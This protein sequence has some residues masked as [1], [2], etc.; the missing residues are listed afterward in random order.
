MWLLQQKKQSYNSLENLFD[1]PY[2]TENKY[3]DTHSVELKETADEFNLSVVLPGV[4]KKD[5]KLEYRDGYVMVEA[6]KKSKLESVTEGNSN[7]SDLTT[8]DYQRQFYVGDIDSKKI[9][10]K[11]NH[12]ILTIILPKKEEQKA[13]LIQ[14]S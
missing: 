1:F 11:L 8:V 10:A 14:I 4:L 5:I 13:Q 12:G 9:S 3:L 6:N 7:V 2:I